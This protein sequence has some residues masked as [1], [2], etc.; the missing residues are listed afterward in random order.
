MKVGGDLAAGKRRELDQRHR[1]RLCHRAADLDRRCVRDVGR[2]VMEMRSETREPVDP[3]LAGR[4]RHA[5][6]GHH[7]W[8]LQSIRLRMDEG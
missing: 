6:G 5:S 3:A 1:E 7:L 2:W 8:D 4:K